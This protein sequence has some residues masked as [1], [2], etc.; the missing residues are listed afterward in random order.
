[1]IGTDLTIWAATGPL[2]QAE[3][4]TDNLTEWLRHNGVQ[5]MV[6]II[7]IVMLLAGLRAN[8]TKVISIAALALVGLAFVVL[9]GNQG[10]QNDVGG[11]IWSLFNNNA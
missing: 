1:M 6:A 3:V 10:M 7:A 4:S 5:T 2:A 11:F 9:S 8:A